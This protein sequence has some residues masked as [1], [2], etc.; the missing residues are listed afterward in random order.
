[1]DAAAP[2]LHNMAMFLLLDVGI[3]LKPGNP[4]VGTPPFAVDWTLMKKHYSPIPVTNHWPSQRHHRAPGIEMRIV[5][6]C[7]THRVHE[8]FTL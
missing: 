5:Y 1:M 4:Q 7:V 6:V 2:A 8:S 3:S